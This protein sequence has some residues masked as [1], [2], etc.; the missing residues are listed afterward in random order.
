M[1]TTTS[2]GT[3]TNRC[4]PYAAGFA[5]SVRESLGDYADDYD[6]DGPEGLTRA[7]RDAINEALPPGVS[8]C[9][10]EFIGPWK[11]ADD[12]FDGYPLTD[13]GGLDIKAIV[14][15]VDFWAIAARHEKEPAMHHTIQAITGS[16]DLAQLM[17][18]YAPATPEDA[19]ETPP[20]RKPARRTTAR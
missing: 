5:Q 16:A 3:W 8:L 6:L 12:A 14:E 15:D 11:A 9:G 13:L 7:Y 18:T 20:S 2:Y 17:N 1:T 4:E 10:D 19:A